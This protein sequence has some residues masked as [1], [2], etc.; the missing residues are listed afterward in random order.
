MK[1]KLK[2]YNRRLFLEK[3]KKKKKINS[4]YNIIRT[5]FLSPDPSI[6]HIKTIDQSSSRIIFLIVLFK[7][8]YIKRDLISFIRTIG[9]TTSILAAVT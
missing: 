3:K 2:I 1:I 4:S 7:D 8:L 9:T 6:N 5:Q